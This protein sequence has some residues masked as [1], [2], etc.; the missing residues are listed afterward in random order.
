V[1]HSL[2]SDGT[3]GLIKRLEFL[4]TCTSYYIVQGQKG[5]SWRQNGSVAYGC[6][7]RVKLLRRRGGGQEG[8]LRSGLSVCVRVW[9]AS[10]PKT[11]R[12]MKYCV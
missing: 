10:L 5:R 1:P 6:Q 8:G 2:H 9:Y 7:L 11:V 12:L 4:L 3:D